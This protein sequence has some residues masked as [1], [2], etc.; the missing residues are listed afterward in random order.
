M[1]ISRA[2]GEQRCVRLRF[3]LVSYT[4][5]VHAASPIWQLPTDFVS[6][7]KI[8]EL[9]CATR[10]TTS[11]PL[12]SQH[13][14]C[15]R[16]QEEKRVLSFSSLFFLDDLCSIFNTCNSSQWNTREQDFWE[17]CWDRE[18][19]AVLLLNQIIPYILLPIS[20]AFMC[21]YTLATVCENC[22]HWLRFSTSPFYSRSLTEFTGLLTI[23]ILSCWKF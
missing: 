6:G 17:K 10:D 3:H 1:H 15:W 13:A 12:I 9:Y 18:F 11:C 20:H 2:V 5:L 14:G 21:T 23:N 19:Y 7:S 16:T 4:R 8:H 22:R